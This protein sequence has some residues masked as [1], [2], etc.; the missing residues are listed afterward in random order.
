MKFDNAGDLVIL[1]GLSDHMVE[2]QELEREAGRHPV[3]AFIQVM[4][5]KGSQSILSFIFPLVCLFISKFS[6]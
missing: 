2:G 3:G 6:L 1:K 5:L 4:S